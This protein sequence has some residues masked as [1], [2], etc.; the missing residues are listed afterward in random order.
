[1]DSTPEADEKAGFGRRLL[2][3]VSA[4]GALGDCL[5]ARPVWWD[6]LLLGGLLVAISN[7]VIP[8]DVW[9]EFM[10]TQALAAGGARAGAEAPVPSGQIVR[11]AGSIA[12]PIFWALFMAL[13]AGIMA[14]VFAFV[15]GDEGRFKQYFS[16]TAHASLITGF[17]LVLVSPLRIARED[18]QLTLSVGTFLQ[19][20]LGDGYLATLANALDLFA[21]WAWIVMGVLFSRFDE[22]RS[23]GSAVAVVVALSGAIIAVIAWFQHRALG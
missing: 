19:G 8:A 18:P 1:M 10:R 11:I 22:R 16:A 5:R 9:G 13:S 12:A 14:F 20:A 17:G 6:A 15:F 23:P 21:I 4:P 7:L 3:L 2:L